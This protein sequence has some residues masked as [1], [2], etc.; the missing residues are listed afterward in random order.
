MQIL[1]DYQLTGENEIRAR[2]RAGYRRVLY[3]LPTGGGKTTVAASIINQARAKGSKILFLAHRRELISQCSERLDGLGVDHGIIMANHPRE[4]ASAVQ[5]GSIQTIHRRGLPWE[6]DIVFI[7]EAHRC[8]GAAYQQ[9]V[10]AC[11]RAVVI[12]ITATPCRTDGKGLSP[13][14]ESM[15][16]GPSLS[17]L[18]AQGYLVP[19]RTYA[20][21]KPN[22]SGVHITAGDYQQ[23]E[24]NE[25]MNKPEIV[26][27]VVKEWQKNAA[28]RLTVVFAV[29][30]KHSIALRDAFRAA[31]VVAEHLDGETPTAE[32]ERLLADL[33][34]G[35]INVLTNCGVLS[36]GWD[37]LDDQ[38]E[39]LTETGWKSRGQIAKG[40][41]MYSWNTQTDKME[42]SPVLD[43]GERLTREGERMVSIK[44]QRIDVRVTENHRFFIKYSD[45]ANRGQMSKAVIEKK[46]IDL[47]SRRSTYSFPI[48]LEFDGFRGVNLSDDELRFVAWFM[49]DGGFDRTCVAISQSKSHHHEIRSLLT[50]LGLPVRERMRAPSASGYANGLPVYEF[51]VKKGTRKGKVVSDGWFKYRE[52]LS[53]DVAP[54]LHH[55]TRAQFMVFWAELLK[56]DGETSGPGKSGWLWCDRQEQ[57]DA[58]TAMAV[59]R[60]LA[61]SYSTRITET[62]K[63]MFRVSVRENN[64][65]RMSSPTDKRSA[66]VIAESLPAS[67]TVWCVS[68]KNGTLVSRRG[69]KIAIIGNCPPVSCVCIVRPTMSLV[70]Y[71]QMAGRTLRTSPGKVD[72]IINDHGGCV[73]RHGL[74]TADREWTLDGEESRPKGK[75][76]KD[77]ADMVKVCP[78]CD[79]V[80]ELTDESCPCGYVFKVRRK[81]TKTVDGELELVAEAKP[82]TEDEKRRRYEWFLTQQYTGKTKAGAPYSPAYAVMKFRALYGH[83]PKRGWREAWKA[84]R[85]DGRRESDWRNAGCQCSTCGHPPCSWCTREPDAEDV[86]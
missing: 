50:R 56:G 23:D 27:D 57:A 66:N 22:L 32:R 78:N 28:G 1:R 79:R 31:G 20:R 2:I 30:I 65:L 58:Y 64:W 5:V 81:P 6:P 52:F 21:K 24:L 73:Y 17:D 76:T 8:R 74:I 46:A 9:A 12:G 36:E 49:T 11:G 71:L 15:V 4:R 25:A 63:K 3:V 84:K 47:V 44:N 18:T 37:C 39:V 53:K 59:T 38:T 86:A 68:N 42:L 14:F 41:L 7:D 75:R 45:P 55:M 82:I 85:E 83:P 19:A 72:S 69:G 43:Y 62:G 54:S 10:N 48:G 77:V 70:L 13:P 33:A 26:G 80:A 35:R 40:D 16:L 34:T 60:G 67:E 51:K 61:A 29:G